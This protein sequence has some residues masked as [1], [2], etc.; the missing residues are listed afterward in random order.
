MTISLSLFLKVGQADVT[1]GVVVGARLLLLE[2]MV[3][4]PPAVSPVGGGG[5]QPHL[6][7]GQSGLAVCRGQRVA[8]QFCRVESAA[9]GVR[10]ASP[11]HGGAGVRH[12]TLRLRLVPQVVVRVGVARQGPVGGAPRLQRT[13]TTCGAGAPVASDLADCTAAAPG[14]SDPAAGLHR[15]PHGHRGPPR[16]PVTVPAAHTGLAAAAAVSDVVVYAGVSGPGRLSRALG[17]LGA[18]DGLP[19]RGRGVG[20]VVAVAVGVSGPDHTNTQ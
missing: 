9:G 8:E 15:P 4:P 17:P 10:T 7:G 11:G 16:P 20:G 3:V 18:P 13:S 2:G 19:V 5:G 1:V 6:V 12:L 14:T